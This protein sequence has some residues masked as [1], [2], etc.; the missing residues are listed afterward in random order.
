MLSICCLVV[1]LGWFVSS[2]NVIL[3]KSPF[4]NPASIGGKFPTSNKSIGGPSFVP[5]FPSKKV[6]LEKEASESSILSKFA[7]AF[8]WAVSR[9]T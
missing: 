7:E 3:K 9:P 2:P 5:K 4:E 8:T 6:D 1:A